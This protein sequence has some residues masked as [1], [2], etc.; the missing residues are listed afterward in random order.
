MPEI[1]RFFGI[2]IQMYYDDHDPPHFHVR[3]GDQRAIVAIESLG[4]I[5]GTLSPRTLGLVVEWAAQH[6]EDLIADWER[7]RAQAPLE[8]IEPLK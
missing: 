8:R 6:R 5:R 4:I 1:C 2:V 3:Y 7:A